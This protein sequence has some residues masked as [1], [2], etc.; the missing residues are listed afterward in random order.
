M[1]IRLPLLVSLALLPSSCLCFDI[2]ELITNPPEMPDQDPPPPGEIPTNA[3]VVTEDDFEWVGACGPG[4]GQDTDAQLAA[5]SATFASHDDGTIELALSEDRC[6]RVSRTMAGGQL[7]SARY[8]RFTGD[9][10]STFVDLEPVFFAYTHDEA[11]WER[12]G[13]G[14][15]VAQLHDST[16]I[17]FFDSETAVPFEIEVREDAANRTRQ[18]T[19]F[20]TNGDV[21][22]RLTVTSAEGG[23]VQ[24]VERL[25]DG[26]LV[27]ET[28]KVDDEQRSQGTCGTVQATP[29]ACA[30]DVV[31]ALDEALRR[32]MKR[33]ADCM[34]KLDGRDDTWLRYI[35]L[36]DRWSRGHTWG[37]FSATC[38]Q[39]R[40]CDTCQ[41]NGEALHIDIGYEQWA[42]MA[43][44]NPSGADGVLFHEMMHGLLGYHPDAVVNSNIYDEGDRTAQLMRR[45]TD[46]VNACEAYCFA[47]PGA[48]VT[49]CT[50][51]ACLET[52]VCDERCA[53]LAGC[54]ERDTSGN[55][56]MSEAVGAACVVNDADSGEEVGT[57]HAT[58]AACIASG[59]AGAGGRCD[60][61]SLSCDPDCE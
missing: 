52:K 25:V 41:N 9:V 5:A 16:A 55:A 3:M 54:I 31:A 51:A 8:F 57:F 40:W 20:A 7:Q 36:M 34:K 47:P 49:Q 60:S 28:T 14:A 37:C 11:V 42:E 30:P 44:S 38:A 53:G 22:W 6:L 46:R 56:I 15:L 50:C 24:V 19:R 61:K 33:G 26:V 58:M 59:C 12:G 39:A 27:S 45:Y 4:S 17:P 21:E 18:T 43:A 32:A 48:S 35:L 13:D 2:L 1:R 29:P 10:G 23:S